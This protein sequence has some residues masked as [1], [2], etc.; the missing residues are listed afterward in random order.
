MVTLIDTLNIIFIEYHIARKKLHDEGKVLDEENL[1]FYAH[2]LFN[3]LN[4]LFSIYGKLIFAWE[5]KNSLGWRRS[6]FPDYKGNRKQQ[7]NEDEYK[8]L[9][10]FFPKIQEVLGYYPCKQIETQNAE[11]D[12]VIYILS[13]KYQDSGITII[14][15]DGD[16]TQIKNFFGDKIEIYNPIRRTYA[17]NRPYIIEEKAICGDASDNIPGLYRIGPKTFE[18]MLKDPVQSKKIMSKGNNKQIYES[19]KKIVDLRKFP[20]DIHKQILDKEGKIPYNEFQPEN[21]EMFFWDNK[22]KQQLD[23]WGNVRENINIAIRNRI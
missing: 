7:K 23:R 19:F 16:L 13:E 22:L 21:I 20:E 5:G 12:D 3:K 15:T 10:S 14:S 11:A 4:S 6:I 8:V 9:K 18:K 1:P 2:L 17:K